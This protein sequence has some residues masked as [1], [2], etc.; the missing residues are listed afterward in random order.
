M[1]KD[2][3]PRIKLWEFFQVN[4]DKAVDQFR[5]LLMAGEI[6]IS[7]SGLFSLTSQI[8]ALKCIVWPQQID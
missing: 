8:I 6:L 5:K 2:V 3:F 1:W 4:V 7:C